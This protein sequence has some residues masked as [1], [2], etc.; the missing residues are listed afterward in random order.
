MEKNSG[1]T[2]PQK[3]HCSITASQRQGGFG[4]MFNAGGCRPSAAAQLR[5]VKHHH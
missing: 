1:N 3:V 2:A 5:R 4:V